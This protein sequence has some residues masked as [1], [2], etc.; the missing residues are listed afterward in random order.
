MDLDLARVS[1]WLHHPPR[2]D[3]RFELRERPVENEVPASVLDLLPAGVFL[4]HRGQKVLFLVRPDAAP[5]RFRYRHQPTERDF[6]VRE[7]PPIYLGRHRVAVIHGDRDA[8]LAVIEAAIDA[9]YSFRAERLC[10]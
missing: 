8:H 10:A 5:L 6:D 4:D 1:H 9:A 3:S 2:E 7:L